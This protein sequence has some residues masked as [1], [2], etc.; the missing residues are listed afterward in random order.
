MKIRGLVSRVISFVGGAAAALLLVELVLR[1]MPVLNGIYAADP[2]A[3]WPTRT[4]IPNSDYTYSIGWNASNIHHGH[5][6]NLGYVAPFDYREGAG[7]VVVIG[8]SYVE[9]MMNDYAETLQGQLGRDLRS[10]QQ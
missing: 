6:N 9:S 10:P 4:L 7:G 1:L 2:S 3:R 8:D 5:I